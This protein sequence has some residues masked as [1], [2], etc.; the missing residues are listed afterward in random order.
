MPADIRYRQCTIGL[1]A[2]PLSCAPHDSRL[3]SRGGCGYIDAHGSLGLMRFF[4][5]PILL[6][7]MIASTSAQIASDNHLVTVTVSP[8]S[9]MQVTGAGVTFDVGEAN[10]VAGQDLMVMTDA[11]TQ[12]LWGTNASAQKI[13]AATSLGTPLFVLKLLAVNPTS[14]SPGVETPLS[15][16]PADLLL[17]IGR[18]SGSCTLRYTAEVLA[19]Q[20]TGVDSHTVTFTMVAQ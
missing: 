11:S 19:S 10:A 20:G 16:V 5:L 1:R 8:I 12:L 14:G 9:V 7:S 4:L 13:T 2:W 15:T 3:E 17:D 18:S 6:L